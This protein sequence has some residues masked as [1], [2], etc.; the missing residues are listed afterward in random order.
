MIVKHPFYKSLPKSMQISFMI[1]YNNCFMSEMMLFLP[2]YDRSHFIIT[3]D[4]KKVLGT[5]FLCNIIYI[6]D[7]PIRIFCK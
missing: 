4:T 5:V 1:T 3:T 6:N 2:F 7:I